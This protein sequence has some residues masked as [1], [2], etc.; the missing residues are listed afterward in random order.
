[1]EMEMV[2]L[3]LEQVHIKYNWTYL[4]DTWISAKNE[5]II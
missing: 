4:I 1:M 2:W 3:K 5:L